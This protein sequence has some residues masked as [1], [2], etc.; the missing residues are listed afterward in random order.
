MAGTPSPKRIAVPNTNMEVRPTGSFALG[1]EKVLSADEC[2]ERRYCIQ[3]PVGLGQYATIYAAMDTSAGQAV[4]VK[5]LH[6]RYSADSAALRLCE[7]VSLAASNAV[8]GC[9]QKLLDSGW[10]PAGGRFQVFEAISGKRVDRVFLELPS[11]SL[12]PIAVFHRL[13]KGVVAVHEAGAV[14]GHLSSSSLWV[15]YSGE[16]KPFAV[17]CEGF[18]EVHLRDGK[19]SEGGTAE[20]QAGERKPLKAVDDVIALARFLRVCLRYCGDALAPHDLGQYLLQADE[21]LAQR[22]MSKIPSA[23]ELLASVSLLPGA[24]AERPHERSTLA[25]MSAAAPGAE[26]PRL[27]VLRNVTQQGLAP[28][29]GSLGSLVRPEGGGG[30][31][32]F[33]EPVLAGKATGVLVDAGNVDAGNPF[34]SVRESRAGERR[35][36]IALGASCCLAAAAVT[37][38]VWSWEK[39]APGSNVRV[40]SHTDLRALSPVA[41]A[42]ASVQSQAKKIPVPSAVTAPEAKVPAQA[43]EVTPQVGIRASAD[44]RNAAR[45]AAVAR[46]KKNK[47]V[48]RRRRSVAAKRK[49]RAAKASESRRVSTPSGQ[50]PQPRTPKRSIRTQL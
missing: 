23:A 50:G 25:P 18:G 36:L 24:E 29:P 19:S 48:L 22:V 34:H 43:Q 39:P 8:G 35:W 11:S 16:K 37:G 38:V 40:T 47:F 27:P 42:I 2:I 13:L 7:S 21:I 45:S 14:H 31:L 3:C 15:E 32:E 30:V 1:A 12:V 41:P 26:C 46:I 5:V 6:R 17:V 44:A 33:P 10:L 28:P 49:A 9:A 4:V 20:P